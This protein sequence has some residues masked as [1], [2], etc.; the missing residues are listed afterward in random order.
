MVAKLE[1]WLERVITRHDLKPP[2][3]LRFTTED[4]SNSAG[5]TR[6]GL[7]AAL[8]RLESIGMIEV[9]KRGSRHDPEWEVK[10]VCLPHHMYGFKRL[11]TL[12]L[13]QKMAKMGLTIGNTVKV[14]GNSLKSLISA[15]R[16]A[17]VHYADSTLYMIFDELRNEYGLNFEFQNAKNTQS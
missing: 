13:A 2:F 5:I 17:G 6:Q 8:S 7:F 11:S 9:L 16:R 3:V 12:F 4:L 10:V 14:P 1:R 15:L